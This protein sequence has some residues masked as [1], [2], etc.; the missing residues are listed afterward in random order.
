MSLASRSPRRLSYCRA[1]ADDSYPTLWH[2]P[3]REMQG[4]AEE[5]ENIDI[6]HKGGPLVG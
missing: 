5:R 3:G 2:S 6:R 1:N 4:A